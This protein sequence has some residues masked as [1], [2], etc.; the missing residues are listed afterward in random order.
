MTN[1]TETP[2]VVTPEVEAPL[3]PL[4]ARFPL[5]PQ[6]FSHTRNSVTMTYDLTE[7]D[8]KVKNETTGKLEQGKPYYRINITKDNLLDYVKYAG[9]DVSIVDLQGK[10]AGRTQAWIEECISPDYSKFDQETFNK[11][12][13]TMSARGTTLKDLKEQ[14]EE[15]SRRIVDGDIP[16]GKSLQD[17]IVE[18]R[19]VGK[20]I[21]ARERKT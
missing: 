21:I 13:D 1:E 5:I 15:L 17:L 10:H 18:F 16:E 14:R 2:A 4:S 9:N 3:A 20:E 11:F 19:E 12:A 8:R 6:S 7:R